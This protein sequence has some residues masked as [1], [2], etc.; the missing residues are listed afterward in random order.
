MIH[1]LMSADEMNSLLVEEIFRPQA[2]MLR[3][4]GFG[5]SIVRG[6]VFEKGA[7]IEGLP[8]GAKVIYR[9]WMV[10]PEEYD[11]F[12]QAVIKVGASLFTDGTK[13]RLTHYLPNWYPLLCNFTPETAVVYCVEELKPTLQ[14]LGWGKYF[15]KDFVKSLKVDGGS[16]VESANDVDKWLNAMIKYRDEIEGGICIRRVEN[17]VDNSECRFFVVNGKVFA[18][19]E[20]NIPFPVIVA[21]QRIKSSFFT[22]DIAQ[23]TDGNFRII[24]LGD[25]Q[26]SDLVGW[27]PERFAAI[28]T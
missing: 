24:E 17:F 2:E 28:W 22:V 25:G 18:P 6:S 12:E 8:L 23:D 13:Y 7:N 20:R 16:I 1:F 21:A 19:D 26:V 14:R 10:K 3:Q 27:D 4:Y 5:V 15:L 9:G 11:R